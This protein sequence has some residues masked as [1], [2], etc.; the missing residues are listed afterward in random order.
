MSDSYSFK[1]N[2]DGIK[3]YGIYLGGGEEAK[4]EATEIL[5]MAEFS[6]G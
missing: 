6:C 5:C 4:G 3:L 2:K 1:R